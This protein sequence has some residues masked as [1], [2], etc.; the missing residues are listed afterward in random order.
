MATTVSKRHRLPSYHCPH[1]VTA[2]GPHSAGPCTEVTESNLFC[3]I[4]IKGAEDSQESFSVCISINSCLETV[5]FA[6]TFFI[7]PI[8]FPSVLLR[9]YVCSP[10]PCEYIWVTRQS[11]HSPA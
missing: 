3:S 9:Y 8:L 7:I 10:V 5:F 4:N 11:Y 1:W 2:L 6:R